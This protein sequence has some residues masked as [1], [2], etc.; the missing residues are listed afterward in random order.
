MIKYFLKEYSTKDPDQAEDIL[1]VT[2]LLLLKL[3][4]TRKKFIEVK[5]NR[6]MI[7][8]ILMGEN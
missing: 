7:I 3:M 2:E 4:N 8:S 1:T 5:K 6:E